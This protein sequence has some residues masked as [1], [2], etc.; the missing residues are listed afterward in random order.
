[1]LL[2]FFLKYKHGLC[3]RSENGNHY[4]KY[5]HLRKYEIKIPSRNIRRGFFM[6]SANQL[7]LFI[8]VAVAVAAACLVA[9][10]IAAGAAAAFAVAAVVLA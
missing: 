8:Q 9:I 2:T 6:E 4:T 3:V 1:M 7:F 10:L 5:N